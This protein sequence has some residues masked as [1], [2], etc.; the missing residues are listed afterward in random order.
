[1]SVAHG[2]SRGKRESPATKPRSGETSSENVFG[3][4]FNAVLHKKLP[5]LFVKRTFPMMHFLRLNIF[6]DGRDI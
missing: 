5:E 3:I 6:R 2:V 1:M 4:I